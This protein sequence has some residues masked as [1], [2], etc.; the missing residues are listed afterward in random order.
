LHHS[1]EVWEVNGLAFLVVKEH[2]CGSIAGMD[3]SKNL[4]FFIFMP[5]D[6]LPATLQA[7]KGCSSA[8]L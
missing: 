2:G 6:V 3:I 1:R 7:F 8:D 4:M 5:P